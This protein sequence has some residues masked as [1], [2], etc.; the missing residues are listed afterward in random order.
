M[1]EKLSSCFDRLQTL[2]IKPTLSNMEKLTQT[3]YDLRD[4]YNEI[5][6]GSADSDRAAVDSEGRNRT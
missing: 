3:L 6:K 1:L 2:E 4:I 5:K